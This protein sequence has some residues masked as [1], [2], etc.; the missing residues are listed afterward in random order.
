MIVHPESV[1]VGR[2]E[3][4]NRLHAHA[5]GGSETRWLH[6]FGQGGIGKSALLRRFLA[7][8][9]TG[10]LVAMDGGR[11]MRQ[12]DVPR[13][14]AERL[15]AIG[16]ADDALPD[17]GA[18]GAAD[19]LNRRARLLGRPLV[20]VIDGID[21]WHAIAPWCLRWF[22]LLEPA[23]RI[24]TA[25]RSML[26][27]DW[28]RGGPAAF[29]ETLRLGALPARDV[30]RY[31]ERRGIDE[32]GD[33]VRLQRFSG[34]VPLA[35]ALAAETIRGGGEA[36]AGR[37]AREENFRLLSVLLADLLRGLPADMHRMLEAASV[38]WRFNE[39][40]LAAALGKELDPAAFRLFAG[41]PFV[42]LTEDGWLLH[43]AVR[44]WAL[45]DFTLRRPSAYEAMRRGALL[46]IRREEEL[47]PRLRGRLQL[48]KMN[49][50]EHP[51]V[52]TVCFAGHPD[53][54]L[55]LRACREADL[56]ELERLYADYHRHAAPMPDDGPLLGGCLRDVWEA[57]PAAF[58]TV[59]ARDELVAFFG[60]VPLRGGM[61][62][63]LRREPLLEPF[64]NGW[65]PVPNAYLFAI[66][67]IRPD[68]EDAV[69]TYMLGTLIN[70]FSRS[71]WIVDLTSL[72][73]WF[74]IFELCGFERAA[75]ADAASAAGTEYRAFVLDLRQEDFIAKLDRSVSRLAPAQAA[76]AR[77][78]DTQPGDAL[79]DEPDVRTLKRILRPGGSLPRHPEA[80]RAYLRLFPHRAMNGASL[81]EAGAAALRDIREAIRRLAEGDE[82]EERL[83]LLLSRLYV[84]N[85]R[86]HERAARSLNLSKATYYRHLNKALAL[87]YR[88][89]DGGRAT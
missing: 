26:T 62:E 85:M 81:E 14:L 54:E 58:V 45:E 44:A 55:E 48:D 69:R 5:E 56:P 88:V 83:G 84:E 33:R 31:A 28:L 9:E 2:I 21:H 40:R 25:G 76:D 29:A 66:I 60:K 20:L 43:D 11:V 53:G 80:I 65:R 52:R 6:V 12:E 15:E 32:P 37:L 36:G 18:E 74:P 24:V 50:H 61:L 10:R 27:G 82:A 78:A 19:A 57:D 30:E 42:R 8:T 23:V 59:W 49:L 4:L 79:A 35:M 89:L 47:H 38:Y 39:E 7:D 3:E 71:E 67:G 13:Q 77:P 68:R 75:W 72:R 22:A 34:G 46:Q 87:L 73:E 70:H 16:T 17:G 1:F 51:L 63:V 86:P 64:L 41:L